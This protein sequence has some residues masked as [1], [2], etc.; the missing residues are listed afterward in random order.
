MDNE[1]RILEIKHRLDKLSQKFVQVMAGACIENFD[2]IK[3]EFQNLH[4]E[5]R[6]LEGKPPRKYNC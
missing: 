4:N 3:L 5:I 1:E 2:E 6:E